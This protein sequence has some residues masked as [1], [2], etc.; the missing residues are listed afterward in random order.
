MEP[1][2]STGLI[3]RILLQNL[4]VVF[5]DALLQCTEAFQQLGKPA[6][7][8]IRQTVFAIFQY[9]RNPATDLADP[10]ASR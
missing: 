8:A 5:L 3:G 1:E 4:L 10:L 9:L 2:S 7:K 6:P